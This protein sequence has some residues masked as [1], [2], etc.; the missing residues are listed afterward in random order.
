MS[1]DFDNP[2]LYQLLVELILFVLTFLSTCQS[3]LME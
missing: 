1:T 3:F 2:C